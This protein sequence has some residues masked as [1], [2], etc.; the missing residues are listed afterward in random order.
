MLRILFII[1]V[2][3]LVPTIIY[4]LWRTYAPR[5]A[6][7][8]YQS[9]LASFAEHLGL[10]LSQL[11]VREVETMKFRQPETAPVQELEDDQIS[12]ASKR[13]LRGTRLGPKEDCLDMS[14][15]RVSGKT[16]LYPR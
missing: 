16:L 14:S 11:E 6:G 1:V 10:F 5:R 15:S 4:V 13:I 3:L 7:D 8:G 12:R 2:P 9:L